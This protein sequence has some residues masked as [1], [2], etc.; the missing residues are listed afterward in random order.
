MAKQEL[1]KPSDEKLKGVATRD[2]RRGKKKDRVLT[3]EDRG[4]PEWA[5]YG[6]HQEVASLLQQVYQ[7]EGRGMSDVF[8]TFV[9][10]CHAALDA[11]PEL[12]TAVL[13]G[14]RDL[15]KLTRIADTEESRRLTAG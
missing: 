3:P 13:D 1:P 9:G 6:A 4:H 8:P 5:C 10:C 11:L 2:L 14:E 15:G 7:Y 12:V